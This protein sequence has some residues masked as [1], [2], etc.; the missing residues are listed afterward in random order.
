MNSRFMTHRW[1][2]QKVSLTELESER[3]S[4]VERAVA[5]VIIGVLVRINCF[6]KRH[7]AADPA[8]DLVED[9]AWALVQ[10]EGSLAVLEAVS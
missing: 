10:D 2:R 8:C 7:W 5:Q 6:H 1:H 9:Q 4:K 3:D